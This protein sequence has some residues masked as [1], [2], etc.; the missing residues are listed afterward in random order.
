MTDTYSVGAFTFRDRT[1]EEDRQNGRRVTPPPG[2]RGGLPLPLVTSNP[3]ILGQWATTQ[4]LTG[5]ADQVTNYR[6]GRFRDNLVA[7][8]LAREQIYDELNDEVHR[9]TGR[10]IGGN[11]VR[12]AFG[13]EID[14][15]RGQFSFD[16][17]A[18]GDM[19]GWGRDN[20]TERQWRERLAELA[21]TD[22]RLANVLAR[23]SPEA[24]TKAARAFR[25]QVTRD[26]HAYI[27][28][29]DQLDQIVRGIMGAP[30]AITGALSSGSPEQVAQLAAGAGGGLGRM[31]LGAIEELIA[32][33][34]IGAAANIA[35]Q[36]VVEPALLEDARRMGE[37]YPASQVWLD[38][39]IAGGLGGTIDL[40]HGVV[41]RVSRPALVRAASGP[42]HE[43]VTLPPSQLDVTTPAP[44]AEVQ[45]ALAGQA[46]SLVVSAYSRDAATA[47]V[48]PDAGTDLN[49]LAEQVRAADDFLSGAGD[50]PVQSRP[51]P[52]ADPEHVAAA[53]RAA[54]DAP[55][56]ASG[57][58]ETIR[59]NG[60]DLPRTFMRVDANTLRF[61]PERFQ[62]KRY[63][64]STG[65]TGSLAGVEAWDS[66]SSGKIVV[67]ED[68]DGT[69]YVA[70]GHQRVALAQQIAARDGTPIE[71]DAYVYRATDGWR[72]RDVRNI[73]AQKNLRET[74]GDPIDTA[75]LLRDA[76]ELI[77]S[78][79]PTGRAGFRV[80]SGLAKLTDEAFRAVRAGRLS[81]ELGAVIGEVASSRPEVQDALV[82]LFQ[83]NPPRTLRE[84]T[85]I[86][87]EALQSELFKT[88]AAQLSMFG[89]APE[90][91]GMQ[92]RAEILR[93]SG[94]QLRGDARLFAVAERNA[95]ALEAAGNIIAKEENARRAGLAEA[96]MRHLDIL[97]TRPSPVSRLLREISDWAAA[98][99]VKPDVAAS[100][101]T[102][103]LIDLVNENGIVG[104]MHERPPPVEAPRPP[105]DTAAVIK[106]EARA[107]E[108]RQAHDADAE[109]YQQSLAEVA[110]ERA[111]RGEIG[112][113]P[114]MDAIGHTPEADM[115]RIEAAMEAMGVDDPTIADVAA[116]LYARPSDDMAL[117]ARARLASEGDEPATHAEVVEQGA[118]VEVWNPFD[119]E[120]ADKLNEAVDG[121]TLPQLAKIQRTF[122]LYDESG[123]PSRT[124]EEFR[125]AFGR[126]VFGNYAVGPAGPLHTVAQWTTAVQ[127][128]FPRYG[129]K[130][131]E[132][133]RLTIVQAAEELPDGGAG[134]YARLGA[135]MGDPKIRARLGQELVHEEVAMPSGKS[136]VYTWRDSRDRVMGVS[137]LR[138]ADDGVATV[139]FGPFHPEKN[140]IIDVSENM[141]GSLGDALQTLTMAV[142]AIERDA[143]EN[144]RAIYHFSGRS[145]THERVYDALANRLQAP[146]GY[147]VSSYPTNGEVLIV[148]D[149]VMAQHNVAWKAHME[150]SVRPHSNQ[151]AR[152]LTALREQTEE[153]LK[154]LNDTARPVPNVTGSFARGSGIWGYS[155]AGQSWI[156]AGNAPIELAR[157]LTLHE[158]GVHVGMEEML[159]PEGFAYALRE[160]E[161]LLADGDPDIAMGRASIPKDTPDGKVIEETLAYALTY[162]DPRNMSTG[163]KGILDRLV[164]SV[165]AW[166]YR[167]LPWTRHLD[168]PL[169]FDDLHMLALGGLRHAASKEARIIDNRALT[170]K[171][172]SMFAPK[173]RVVGE[174]ILASG[175]GWLQTRFFRGKGDTRDLTFLAPRAKG[176]KG[177]LDAYEIRGPIYDAAQRVLNDPADIAAA[178]RAGQ[179][180]GASGVYVRT[181]KGEQIIALRGDAIR[182]AGASIDW[183][184]PASVARA[185]AERLGAV[186]NDLEHCR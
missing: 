32:R 178:V 63:E 95:D 49:A 111:M 40:A 2:E 100:R 103:R 27:G 170:E 117:E 96:M 175:N 29:G 78:S 125:R 182:P 89:D 181:S 25:E 157:G 28:D 104:L 144:K 128:A 57:T 123:V 134:Y 114:D 149:D 183:E 81:P 41:E 67:F 147:Q 69:Q 107:A 48:M 131:L 39:I 173:P 160:T 6:Y 142:A 163:L 83:N 10:R 94:N 121:A 60:A 64:G 68:A 186:L 108:L 169:T 158:V 174:D 75:T 82:R 50:Y 5:Y 73:A 4:A 159:G 1:E 135:S 148:R 164:N 20:D 115:E 176:L 31:G 162:A 12:E 177:E 113:M 30:G 110:V 34:G 156:V 129:K 101:F 19:S 138:M 171:L 127:R 130:L 87:N 13:L 102:A 99:K 71:L 18:T 53:A 44:G 165:R 91:A 116:A 133:G 150:H 77:D 112:D 97:A 166:A 45:R 33:F 3:I 43:I 185:D 74:P 35:G 93:L 118:T 23:S 7:E 54:D 55:A 155:E 62:Y 47:R 51:V 146:E 79:I 42:L 126:E 154:K 119:F 153:K 52:L 137:I 152:E 105:A 85:F 132:L 65:S 21:R 72:D 98:E 22:P 86:A 141:G 14:P 172:R 184:N 38:F 36:A 88:Q 26:Y 179:E 167:T 124:R 17:L 8:R 11:P 161:R 120:D 59:F 180:A 90:L 140:K 136:D 16:P 139:V 80:A 58:R 122:G 92:A 15:F 9:I 66:Q 84:A 24:V 56:P 151:F 76:P 168:V 61:A 46:E 143:M 109:S 106:Q 37:E 70:D 145:E